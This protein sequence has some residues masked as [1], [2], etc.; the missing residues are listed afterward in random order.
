VEVLELFDPRFTGRSPTK[1]VDEIDD[2]LLEVMDDLDH[3][4]RR[5]RGVERFV[6]LLEILFQDLP[7]WR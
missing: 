1:L 2:A 5:F 4:R 3:L 7:R 6:Q